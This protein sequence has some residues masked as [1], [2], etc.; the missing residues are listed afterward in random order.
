[1]GGIG[2]G[3]RESVRSFSDVE[4]AA[5]I[6]MSR[7]TALETRGEGEKVELLA[8]YSVWVLSKNTLC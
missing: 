6:G 7:V 2:E 4:P 5:C 3:K 1:M 8:A